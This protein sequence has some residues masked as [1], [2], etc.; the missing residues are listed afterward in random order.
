MPHSEPRLSEGKTPVLVLVDPEM[1]PSRRTQG[2][3]FFLH[4]RL[5]R[6]SF[7]GSLGDAWTRVCCRNYAR[8]LLQGIPV[9]SGAFPPVPRG[10]SC[11]TASAAASLLP[12]PD[13]ANSSAWGPKNRSREMAAAATQDHPRCSSPRDTDLAREG[14][15][16]CNGTRRGQPGN[17]RANEAAAV[18]PFRGRR[19][20]SN[21]ASLTLSPL[22]PRS[23]AAAQRVKKKKKAR[24]ISR[25]VGGFC[26]ATSII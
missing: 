23:S 19:Q 18:P 16:D 1:S 9:S 20:R 17:R 14:E 11:T 26:D 21:S 22:P 8:V 5:Q 4:A 7:G 25:I 13:R 10:G 6:L 24:W 3:M 2:C 15:R 12:R